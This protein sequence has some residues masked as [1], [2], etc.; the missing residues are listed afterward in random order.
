MIV[1]C[2]QRVPSKLEAMAVVRPGNGGGGYDKK[3]GE[4]TKVTE[5]KMLR[6]SLGKT[7]MDKIQNEDIR[8]TIGVDKLGE[9]LRWLGHVVRREEGCVRRRIRGFAVGR[10]RR[11]TPKGDEGERRLIRIGDPTQRG[12]ETKRRRRIL[13]QRKHYSVAVPQ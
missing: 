6:F 2:D 3:V 4:K 10:R 7:R 8:K 13:D 5:M 11:G 9:R 12:T 1:L